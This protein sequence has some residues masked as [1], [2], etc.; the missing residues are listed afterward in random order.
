MWQK[1]KNGGRW[2]HRPSF[3]ENVFDFPSKSER[4][5]EFSLPRIVSISDFYLKSSIP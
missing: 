4:K 2:D 3:Q 1:E 5:N